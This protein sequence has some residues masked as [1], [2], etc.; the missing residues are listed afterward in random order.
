MAKYTAPVIY[1][2]TNP[3]NLIKCGTD[4][5]IFLN[6]ENIISNGEYNILRINDTDHRVILS[7]EALNDAGFV[8][9][10]HI[11]RLIMD[12]MKG[13][14]PEIQAVLANIVNNYMETMD[15]DMGELD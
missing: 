3:Y 8:D 10:D 14:T 9:I 2:S 15:F 12:T 5:G 4:K 13:L 11:S 1:V 7:K 6:A